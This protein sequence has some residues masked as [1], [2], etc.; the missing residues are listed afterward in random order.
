VAQ[1]VNISEMLQSLLSS[2]NSED[3]QESVSQ[4]EN[5]S[6]NE[7]DSANDGFDFGGFDFG[8]FFEK[9]DIDMLLKIGE[10]FA[11]FNRPDKN[12]E[13]LRALKP[14]MRDE[15]KEKIDTAIKIMRIVALWPFLRESGFM[16]KI[17]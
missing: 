12:A 1:A 7:S 16:D 10:L 15:N 2:L 13:L 9:I 3:S 8:S 11:V 5:I 6:S 4:D 14:L 17:F